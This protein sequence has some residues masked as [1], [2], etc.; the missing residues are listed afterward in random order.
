MLL[1]EIVDNLPELYQPVYGHPELSNEASRRCVDRAGVVLKIYNALSLYLA[2]PLKILD[3]GCAQGYFSFIL[4][5]KGAAVHG[6][7]RLFENIKLCDFLKN[8]SK[9]IN[10]VF[11]RNSI[12]DVVKNLSD[13]KYDIVLGLNVFHHIAH[14]HGFDYVKSL[15]NKI[16]VKCGVIIAE[17]ATNEEPLYWSSSQPQDTRELFSDVAFVHKC[18]QFS[19]HLSSVKRPIYFS[20]GK[21]WFL[22]GEIDLFYS[23]SEK[24]Y[25]L[26]DGIYHETRKYY[27]S[28]HYIAKLFI[29]KGCF[30]IDN[31]N[32]IKKEIEF[33]KN[34]P[35]NIN[36]PKPISWGGDENEVWL[37]REKKKGRLLLDIIIN[38]CEYD[39]DKVISQIADQLE[40]L[41]SFGLYHNDIRTWNVM[42]DDKGD[43]FFIDYGSISREKKDCSWPENIYLSFFV[44]VYEVV[45]KCKADE[46]PLRPFS[47]KPSLLK[48]PYNYC[49]E[50]MLLTPISNWSFQLIKENLNLSKEHVFG[51]G[52]NEQFYEWMNMAEG[53]VNCQSSVVN[54]L[55][56]EVD[57]CKRNIKKLEKILKEKEKIEKHFLNSHSWKVTA[58]LRFFS[59]IVKSQP[60]HK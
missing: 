28:E 51:D 16:A 9:K 2:R 42:I 52:I 11:E 29:L 1:N 30:E 60:N 46:F 17:C 32:E 8:E 35:P 36:V 15:I 34:P 43:S 3:L 12:E 13:E 59:Q 20:S 10:V 33:L 21:Y 25:S 14:E 26:A 19:T 40:I 58:P 18:G 45:S 37:V 6:V 39:H 47:I 38:S 48:Y 50:N 57:K 31:K 53:F 54:N 24:P 22:D 41:E 23:W 27:F 5:E 7:D 44:F 4:A 49:L 56:D 55:V